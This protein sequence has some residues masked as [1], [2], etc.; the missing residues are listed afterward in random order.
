MILALLA[1]LFLQA[2]P[3]NVGTV[4]GIV[5]GAGGVP[6]AGVRVYAINVK[7]AEDPATPAAPLESQ[8]Q[9]DADGRYR[10]EISGGRYYIGSGSVNA[11]TY[12]PGAKN[13]A[14]ARVV[15]VGAGR[16]VEGID[17]SSYIPATGGV[18]QGTA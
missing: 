11:P 5:R 9:T 10:L 13:I 15:E 4:T 14:A 16:I 17:F 2:V 6:A 18:A 7:E 3:Q 1:T 8:T 12:Y